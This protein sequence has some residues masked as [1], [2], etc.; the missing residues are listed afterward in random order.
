MNEFARPNLAVSDLPP[1]G[2]SDAGKVL[3]ADE[4][5]VPVWAEASGG[6]TVTA[7]PTLAGT[8]A[9]L[10]GLQVGDTKYKVGGGSGGGVL[11]ATDTNGTLDKTLQE[12]YDAMSGGT[13]IFVKMQMDDGSVFMHYVFSVSLTD[14]QV[15]V[16]F[17]G[18]GSDGS[19]VAE[20]ASGYP[21]SN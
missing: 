12:L 9:D 5:G 10:T 4:T 14:L 21:T 7:N 3:T 17:Y 6:T 1:A 18:S 16:H 11:V 13:V 20:S 19:Y 8:E 15:D 2:A